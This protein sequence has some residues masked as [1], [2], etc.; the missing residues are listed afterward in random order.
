MMQRKILLFALGAMLV[1]ACAPYAEDDTEYKTAMLLLPE[2]QAEAGRQT[3]VSLGCASCHAVAWDSDLPA[4]SAATPGPELGVDVA[5]LGPDGLATA[6]VAP[7]HKVPEQYRTQTGGARSPMVDYT[8]TLTIRQLA[9]IVAY[10]ERQ[11]L[12]TQVRTGPG[13]AG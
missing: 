8:G 12:E 4:P 13:A 7:S 9:D 11:G 10:L 5:K 1:A 6:I 3:F 2:G